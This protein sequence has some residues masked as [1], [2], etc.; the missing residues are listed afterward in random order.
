MTKKK[1]TQATPYTFSE[2]D[3]IANYDWRLGA[4]TTTIADSIHSNGLRLSAGS[5]VLAVCPVQYDMKTMLLYNMP[6][7]C[8]LLLDFAH[9]L[10]LESSDILSQFT[11]ISVDGFR[12]AKND[13][14]LIEA[15]ERRM[16]SAVFAF[17]AIEAFAN[18]MIEEAYTKKNYSYSDP[19]PDTGK[20]YTL[21][22]IERW[23]PLETKLCGV[24]PEIAAVKRPKGTVL[25]QYFAQ[26]RKIRHYVIHPKLPDRIQHAP[27]A[28]VLWKMLTDS[29][30]RDFAID[31]KA[32]MMH[33]AG[34]GSHSARWLFKCPF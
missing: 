22:E 12:T 3:N 14:S 25:W 28:E 32:L 16:A 15:L 8:A 13:G 23:M 33:Y 24:L 7:V 21:D 10:F 17:T 34:N 6:N 4:V 20:P 30:F 29:K 9:R 18:E 31:A 2:A 27:D 19:N 26:I 1:K 5:V 11:E